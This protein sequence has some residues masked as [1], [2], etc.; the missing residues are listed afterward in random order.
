MQ[1]LDVFALIPA[2]GIL[3][4]LGS[5][6][7]AQKTVEESEA[8]TVRKLPAEPPVSAPGPEAEK[9]PDAISETKG[10]FE[11]AL[12]G[13]LDRLEEDVRALKAKAA[14]LQE[15]AKARWIETAADLDAKFQAAESKLD[16]VRKATGDAWAHLRDGARS[17]W[18]DLEDAVRKAQAE[19]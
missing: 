15:A 16:E 3:A 10:D 9:K 7:C 18:K 14:S 2:L 11:H 4:T 6:G 8:H 13:S 19:F 17:A 1:R 12:N 5:Q